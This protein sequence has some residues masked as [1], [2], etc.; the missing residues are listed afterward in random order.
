MARTERDPLNDDELEA[1]FAEARAAAPVPDEALAAR[2]LAD[3]DRVLAE[4]AIRPAPR[5]PRRTAPLG[6]LLATLGGWRA[7]AGLATATIA[8]V[9]LGFA[10]PETVTD[11]IDQALWSDMSAQASYTL[12]DLQPVIGDFSTLLEES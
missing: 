5:R 12:E 10:G 8:G 11:G 7:I 2:I 3:A 1:L 6:I 9:W 4:R